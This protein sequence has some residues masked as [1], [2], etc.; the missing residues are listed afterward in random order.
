MS[1]I[2]I[3]GEDP[4]LRKELANYL[5]N[6]STLEFYLGH[7]AIRANAILKTKK[8]NQEI[9]KSDLSKKRIIIKEC[10]VYKIEFLIEE[11]SKLNQGIGEF[12]AERKNLIHKINVFNIRSDSF[13]IEEKQQNGLFIEYSSED[14][15]GLNNRL[16][17]F[18]FEDSGITEFFTKF[19][20]SIKKLL[21]LK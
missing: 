16:E 10:I 2:S 17:N 9:I 5:I 3:L 14:L 13:V 12:N 20:E 11:W 8:T 6:F 21:N 18:I 7:M 4:N 1:Y 19:D 15:K